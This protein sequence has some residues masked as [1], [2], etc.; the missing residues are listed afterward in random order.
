MS[1]FYR[2]KKCIKLFYCV[3]YAGLIGNAAFFYL[4]MSIQFSF[5]RVF[6]Y[7]HGRMNRLLDFRLRNNGIQTLVSIFTRSWIGVSHDQRHCFSLARR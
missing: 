1:V 6:S 4:S 7:K 3:E 2:Q 5:L